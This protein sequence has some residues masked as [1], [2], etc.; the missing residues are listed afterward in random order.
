MLANWR[1]DTEFYRLVEETLYKEL[2]EPTALQVL[3][4]QIHD[5]NPYVTQN[6]ARDLLTRHDNAVKNHHSGTIEVIIHGIPKLGL[7]SDD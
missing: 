5:D 4:K 6:A 7:P 2:S 3:K 1:K